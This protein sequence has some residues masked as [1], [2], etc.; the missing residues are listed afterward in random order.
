[1]NRRQTLLFVAVLSVVLALAA[2]SGGK[3]GLNPASPTTVSVQSQDSATALGTAAGTST[4]VGTAAVGTAAARPGAVEVKGLIKSINLDGH[5]FVLVAKN[6]KVLDVRVTQKTAF[7]AGSNPRAKI[8][9]R[10][11]KAGMAVDVV[12]RLDK[13]ELVAASVVVLKTQTGT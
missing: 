4:A 12:G 8:G 10:S 5:T 1:M 11:L 3:T 6:G 7:A 9:F 13:G 2:C